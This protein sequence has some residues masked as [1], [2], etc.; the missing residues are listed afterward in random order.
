MGLWYILF[1]I[2]GGEYTT[3]Y[4]GIALSLFVSTVYLC[5]T[6]IRKPFKMLLA[7]YPDLGFFYVYVKI[8]NNGMK[9]FSDTLLQ[10]G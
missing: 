9:R 3:Y 1:K 4:I 2:F 10:I 5:S 7:K 8:I 6:K